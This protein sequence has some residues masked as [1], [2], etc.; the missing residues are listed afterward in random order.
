MKIRRLST[1]DPSF[2]AELDALLAYEATADEKLE[3][4]V[5]GILAD[6]KRRGDEAVLEYTN[7]FDRLP[8]TDAAAM[9]LPRAELKAAFDGI[10]AE[11]R[12]AL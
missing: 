6:V 5:A 3:A 1:R 2:N 8:L 10:S 11:Q 7:K 9:E 4:T 12:S